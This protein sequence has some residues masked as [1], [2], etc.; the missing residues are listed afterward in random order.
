MS[1]HRAQSS[2]VAAALL[3]GLLAGACGDDLPSLPEETGSSSSAGSSD[4]ASAVYDLAE[5][6][7]LAPESASIHPLGEPL[8]LAARVTDPDG[9][10]L[11]V[12]EVAWSTDA[13]EAALLAGLEGEVELPAGIYELSA[14][15]HLP[16]GDR[17]QSTVGGV[18][19][20]ARWTG[21]YAGDVVL[22]V[23]AQ[24][25]T[26]GPLA[27][28]CEGPLAFTVSLDGTDAPVDDGGCT[29]SV[30]GQSFEATYAIA[31]V[32]YPAGLVRGTVDLAL[33]TPLGAF[34]LPLEWAGAF[35]DDRFSA[36]ISGTVEL[37]FIG[38]AE[39]SGSLQALLVDRYVDPDGG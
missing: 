38:A 1:S 30:L 21:E 18:R 35:Y 14:T 3:L 19:V 7:I 13:A 5:L 31:M 9:V 17:L 23:E 22:V 27:L 16:N 24:L 32:I 26:G 11:A 33:D 15:A 39:V 34:D 2:V 25:P 29:I 36:G 37:P 8:H 6:E 10:A 28:R 12:D 4:D 20:Q